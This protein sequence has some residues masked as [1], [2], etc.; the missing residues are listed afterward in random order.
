[1]NTDDAE[2]EI[3]DLVFFGGRW[4]SAIIVLDTYLQK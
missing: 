3:Y 4:S 1:M 2:M